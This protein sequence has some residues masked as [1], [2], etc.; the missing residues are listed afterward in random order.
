VFMASRQ[1][2]CAACAA[3]KRRCHPQLPQCPRCISRGLRCSY[4]NEPLQIGGSQ[5]SSPDKL[6][7]AGSS[8]NS[9]SG[10]SELVQ[11]SLSEPHS[12]LPFSWA[13]QVNPMGFRASDQPLELNEHFIST[14]IRGTQFTS[15]TIPMEISRVMREIDPWSI[16][17]MVRNIT[18]WPALFVHKLEVPFIHSPTHT[19]S[20]PEPLQGTFM[21]CTG[22]IAK[23][24]ENKSLVLHV[25]EQR[26]EQLLQQQPWLL[27][28]ETHLATLQAVLMLHWIQLWDGDIRQRALA[29]T[30]IDTINL[31]AFQLHIRVSVATRQLSA[32]PT[33]EQ[34][35]ALESSRRTVIIAFVVHGVYEATKSGICPYISTMEQL[36]FTV[37]CG[38]WIAQDSKDW[39]RHVS[40][41]NLSV[42]TYDDFSRAWKQRAHSPVDIF[43]KLLLIPCVWP[44]YKHLLL[45]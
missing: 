12:A 39:E 41:V 36:Q 43:N 2:S 18:S 11:L 13:E 9:L 34:W 24:T 7:R 22:Y 38:P 45:T 40:N 8:T 35:I 32:S 28:L 15:A 30:H 21:A 23:T 1:K 44:R 25:I 29:E 33:W 6:E 5:I 26:V 37:D 27:S 16:D 10:R 4:K 3:A 42:T 20:M 19:L 14:L 31:W 17:C